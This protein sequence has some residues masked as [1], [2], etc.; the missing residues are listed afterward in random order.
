MPFVRDAFLFFRPFVLSA[1][2]IA[3]RSNRP[4]GFWLTPPPLRI[5]RFRIEDDFALWQGFANLLV[6]LLSDKRVIQVQLPKLFEFGKQLG[7][8]VGY[9]CAV[10]AEPLELRQAAERL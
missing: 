8:G 6:P 10:E 9:V 5:A 4:S 2:A 3:Q 7:T 1:F